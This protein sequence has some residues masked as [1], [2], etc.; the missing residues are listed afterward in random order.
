MDFLPL[1]KILSLTSISFAFALALTPLLSNFLYKNGL[2][3]NIRNDGSTPIFTKMHAAKAGTPTMGGVLIWGTVTALITVFWFLDRILKID[4]FHNLNFL[5]RK[6]TLLPLGAFLGA[7]LVGLL[8]DWLDVRKKGFKGQGL[9]FRSKIWLYAGVAVIGAWWFYFKLGFS[10]VNFP[11]LGSHDLGFWFIPFFMLA[12]VAT[13]FAVDLTDGL[14]GLAGGTLLIAF[15]AYGL[16]AYTQGKTDLASLIGV[17]CG[18]LLAF[19]WFN[20][21]PARFFMGD[22]GAMG[23]GVLLAIVAFLTDSVFLLGLVGFVFLIEA[24]STILQILSKKYFKRKIFLSSPLH[25]HFEALGWP[26]TKVT[27]RF[28]IL[29]AVSAILGVIVYFIG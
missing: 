10:S 27:M 19:L 3:K 11:F 7:S 26:E 4:F 15:F 25:H 12:V 17:V 21:Y 13:S 6:E 18:S 9:R 23:M 29:A 22:T 20:V 2:G 14:D 24:V 16:I 8:D 1:T 28:W 5:T